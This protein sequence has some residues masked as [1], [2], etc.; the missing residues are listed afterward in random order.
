MREILQHLAFWGFVA[1][2]FILTVLHWF[3]M[4]K[5]FKHFNRNDYSMFSSFTAWKRILKSG[6]EK[7]DDIDPEVKKIIVEGIKIRKAIIFNFT[8]GLVIYGLTLIILTAK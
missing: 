7:R 8:F 6:Y 3:N 4:R 2:C 1:T 5:L